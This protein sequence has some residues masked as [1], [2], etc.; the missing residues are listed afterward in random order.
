MRT[1]LIKVVSLVLA[2]VLLTVASSV[3]V[4]A[5]TKPLNLTNDGPVVLDGTNAGEVTVSIV[6]NE[7][8]SYALQ[9]KFA[10]PAGFTLTEIKFN[11]AITA[12]TEDVTISDVSKGEIAW[13]DWNFSDNASGEG[14]VILT[15]TYT[16]A[17]GTSAGNYTIAFTSSTYAGADGEVNETPIQVATTVKVEINEPVIPTGLKGDVDLSGEVDLNDLVA[18]AQHIGEAKTITDPLALNNAE[19][20]GEGDVDLN[21]LVKIAQYV[22]EAIDSLD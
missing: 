18:L 21:D 4:T 15:A 19:V 10:A 22:G 14:F 13:I 16:V 8:V 3:V 12:D 17:A 2:V 11:G 20:T 5:A 7:N 1:K 6:C 9:G